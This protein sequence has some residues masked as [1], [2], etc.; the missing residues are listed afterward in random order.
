MSIKSTAAGAYC[1]ARDNHTIV[2]LIDKPFT[3]PFPSVTLST[4]NDIINI[5]E[6][7]KRGRLYQS[8]VDCINH[9]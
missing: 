5:H 7:F 4:H 9:Q 1:L 3:I 8:L 2:D 6:S